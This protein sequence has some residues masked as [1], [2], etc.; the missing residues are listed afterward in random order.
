MTYQWDFSPV[1]MR[2][3]LLL[4]GL[5][6]TVKI[7]AIAILFGVMVGLVLALLR[8]SPR[9]YLRLPAAVFVEFYRN[10]PPIVH[11]FWFFYALPVVLNISLD[12]LVAAVLALSTQSGAFYAEVFRGGIQSIERGQWEGARALGM[13]HTQLMRRI[14][15]PQAATRMIAPF[16]E[17]S[18]ELIKT[19]ALA[20]TL[21]YSEL[22]YQAMMVNSETF[23]PL[24]VYTAVALLYLVLLVSCSAL[25][26]L[27]EARL[28]A[29]R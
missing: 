24:E 6:N 8:L 7:A 13:S 14:V 20:S 29:Y 28:V 4:D 18:F 11:F 2:W 19:T 27:A 10:T 1:L 5:L 21:A 12:P 17:R 23:R 15:L 25:A 16:V 3:P 22:L 9:R 26:R